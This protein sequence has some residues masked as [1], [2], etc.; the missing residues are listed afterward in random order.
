[1]LN[2][3]K[4]EAVMS[5]ILAIGMIISVSLVLVGGIIYLLQHGSESISLFLMQPDDYSTDFNLILNNALSFSPFGIIEL[6]LLI[7]VATQIIRVGLLVWFYGV[8][9]DYWFFFISFFVLAVLVCSA[10]KM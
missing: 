4:I 3:R 7:L 9:R 1:M 6:G 8:M 5:T 10:G 2:I